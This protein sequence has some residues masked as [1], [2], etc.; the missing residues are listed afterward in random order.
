GD[1]CGNTYVFRPARVCAGQRLLQVFLCH[2]TLQVRGIFRDRACAVRGGGL[3]SVTPDVT[4]T[5]QI[6][7]MVLHCGSAPANLRV[8]EPVPTVEV[9]APQGHA[10]QF[11]SVLNTHLVGVCRADAGC[12]P[13]SGQCSPTT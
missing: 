1:L 4:G 7:G 13:V 10:T 8:R 2:L 5:T 6:T 11:K 9:A 12:C 3:M